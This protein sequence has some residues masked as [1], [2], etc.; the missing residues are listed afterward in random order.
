[1]HL[2]LFHLANENII[3]WHKSCVSTETKRRNSLFR[4]KQENHVGKSSPQS[5]PETLWGLGSQVSK[6][7]HQNKSHLF[8]ECFMSA[9]T[10]NLVQQ[11][12]CSAEVRD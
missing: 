5:F 12:D 6:Q 2:K 7:L 1:M 4:L 8:T 9:L 10:Y 11:H 3:L